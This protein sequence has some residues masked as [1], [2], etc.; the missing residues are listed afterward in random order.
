MSS[1]ASEKLTHDI[2]NRDNSAFE[3]IRHYRSVVAAIRGHKRNERTSESRVV[4]EKLLG[5]RLFCQPKPAMRKEVPVF[6]PNFKD[7]LSPFSQS[8]PKTSLALR[9]ILS[10][11]A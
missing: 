9:Q 5:V 8:N 3:W 6:S 7:I 11:A 2:T 4:G 1:Q 10:V